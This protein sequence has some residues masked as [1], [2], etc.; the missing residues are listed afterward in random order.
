MKLLNYKQSGSGADLVLI[1]GLFG[2]LDNLN[3][4]AKELSQYFKVTNLDVRNHGDSFHE[5]NM[6]YSDLARDIINLLDHLH[7]DKAH[8]LGHSMGGKIAMEIA[9]TFPERV[10]KL[11]VADISPVK[12]PAH[13]QQIIEGLKNIDLALVNNRRDADQ[14]LSAYIDNIGVRQFLL[15]NLVKINTQYQFKC[16][17]DF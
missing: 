11:I 8:I 1:H 3:M 14:Q 7:I 16:N 5:N 15:R 9:L 6:N 4:I 12:Y 13:H 17:L 10:I 2:S